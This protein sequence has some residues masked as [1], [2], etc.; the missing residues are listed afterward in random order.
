MFSEE[1]SLDV[2]PELV[3]YSADRAIPDRNGSP[4]QSQLHATFVFINRDRRAGCSCGNNADYRPSRIV[5][6]R[7][8]SAG[9]RSENVRE[10]EGSSA[11][12]GMADELLL[13]AVENSIPE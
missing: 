10:V 13:E 11:F 2:R 8:G 5:K 7:N 1:L 9:E 12:V 3:K 4:A 6:I